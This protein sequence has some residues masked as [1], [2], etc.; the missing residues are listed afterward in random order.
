MRLNTKKQEVR[1]IHKMHEVYYYFYH[2]AFSQH[3]EV[4]TTSFYLALRS[5]VR[6][7]SL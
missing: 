3:H 6:I 1:Q 5:F 4:D 7:Y 2:P